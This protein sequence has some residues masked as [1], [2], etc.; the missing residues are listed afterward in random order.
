M[1]RILAILIILSLLIISPPVSGQKVTA[2]VGRVVSPT[3]V[4]AKPSAFATVMFTAPKGVEVAVITDNGRYFGI[5]M[6]NRTIAWISKKRVELLDFDVEMPYPVKQPIERVSKSKNAKS[7]EANKNRLT[8]G[9]NKETEGLASV[10]GEVVARRTLPSVVFIVTRNATDEP[11]A[12]GSGFFV[13]PGIIV[14]N[15]H[16]VKNVS[17]VSFALIGKKE[18]FSGAIVASDK[19]NDLALIRVVDDVNA[20]SLPLGDGSAVAIGERVYAVGNPEGFEGTFSE[21]IISGIRVLNNRRLMQFTAPVSHG[22][23]GGP[24]ISAKGEVVGITVATYSDGQ[25]LNFAIPVG[26]L[27]SVILS[28]LKEN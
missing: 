23:S 14:T 4:L 25:N 6:A 10:G 13:R 8:G 27:K 22:S 26:Y 15:W 21:G 18:W 2:Q 12:S 19:E 17:K 9:R 1:S 3:G 7:I 24:L 16:L 28:Y 20:P 11:V 5:L